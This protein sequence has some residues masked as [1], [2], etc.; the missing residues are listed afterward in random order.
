MVAYSADVEFLIV[1]E[2]TSPNY[3][4]WMY[5]TG[6]FSDVVKTILALSY[7]QYFVIGAQ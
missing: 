6:N 5:Q 4:T 7:D 3:E 1:V 2:T